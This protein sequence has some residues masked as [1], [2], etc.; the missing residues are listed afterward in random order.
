MDQANDFLKERN[1]AVKLQNAFRNKKA[2]DVFATRYVEKEKQLANAIA[3]AQQEEA[4]KLQKT[5]DAAARIQNAFRNQ[6]TKKI[7]NRRIANKQIK[8]KYAELYQPSAILQ[9]KPVVVNPNNMQIKQKR[10]K[11]ELNK[12]IEHNRRKKLAAEH[13]MK[14]PL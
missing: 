7:I 3:Q 14:Y 5:A 1:A 8:K 13:L 11:T 10:L 2:I 12:E 4:I 9:S 6:K